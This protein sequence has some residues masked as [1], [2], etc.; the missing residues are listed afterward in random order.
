MEKELK[1]ETSTYLGSDKMLMLP[2]TRLSK[3]PPSGQ[4]GGQNLGY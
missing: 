4:V 2:N 1:K 3:V